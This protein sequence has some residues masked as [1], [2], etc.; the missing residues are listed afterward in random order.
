MIAVPLPSLV[1]TAG[2]SDEGVEDDEIDEEVWFAGF[3][4][5]DP[6]SFFLNR[7]PSRFMAATWVASGLR[8]TAFGGGL[9]LSV[10]SYNTMAQ[11]RRNGCGY[12][13]TPAEDLKSVGAAC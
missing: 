11:V 9:L 7:P 8:R 4:R 1:R 5:S 3:N 10:Q 6:F 12:F 2:A 13:S